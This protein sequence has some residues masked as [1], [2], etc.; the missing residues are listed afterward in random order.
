[1]RVLARR[2]LSRKVSVAAVIEFALWAGLV[3]VLFGLV[4]TFMHYDVVM[5]LEADLQTVFPAGAG[6]VAFGVMTLLW[7]L[8][9]LAGMLCGT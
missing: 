3:H 8:L 2:M 9:L 4:W 6:L 5:R 1:M 7:P